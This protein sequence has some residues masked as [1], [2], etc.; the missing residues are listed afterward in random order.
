MM[1]DQLKQIDTK[2]LD[3]PET[4]FV[5][6]IESRVFQAIA[7]QCLERI[8]GIA[9]Q[10]GSLIENWLSRDSLEGIKGIH[11]EQNAKD[12]SVDV[13]VEVNVAY[14]VSIPKKAEEIQTK[15]V[16]DISRLTGLHVGS[17]HVIF[18]NLISSKEHKA[19]E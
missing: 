14:G 18:K 9:L 15:I 3:L 7:L 5:Q 6:G 19:P 11:V 13:K 16:Q 4:V 1:H 8:E 2:E 12:H 10:E 17:V